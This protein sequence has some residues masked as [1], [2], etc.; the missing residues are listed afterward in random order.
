MARRK[1]PWAGSMNLVVLEGFA[2]APSSTKVSRSSTVP[3][4]IGA[5]L[6]WLSSFLR[7]SECFNAD[8]AAYFDASE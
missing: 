3:E 7:N 2:R 1:V 5:V 4:K 6:T 8:P